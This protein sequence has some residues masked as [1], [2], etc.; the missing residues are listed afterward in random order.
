[1]IKNF[2]KVSL[3]YA[4]GQR[5]LAVCEEILAILEKNQKPMRAT[6]LAQQIINDGPRGQETPTVQKVS[7]YLRKLVELGLVNR[8]EIDHRE[9]TVTHSPVRYNCWTGTEWQ[10]VELSPKREAVVKT[11][12]VMFS[13]A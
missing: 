6:E 2:E 13:L 4:I 5:H 9:I 3:P 7:A 12:T 8:E 11:C 10:L 1:M